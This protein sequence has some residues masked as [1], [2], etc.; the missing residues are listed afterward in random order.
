MVLVYQHSYR[1][2][3]VFCLESTSAGRQTMLLLTEQLVNGNAEF[4][5]SK[6]NSEFLVESR[7]T[8]GG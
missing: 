1:V 4:T 6:E 5:A 3:F 8:T 7:G 2:S